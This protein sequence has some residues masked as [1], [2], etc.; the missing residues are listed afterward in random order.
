MLHEPQSGHSTTGFRCPLLGVKRTLLGHCGNCRG[1]GIGAAGQRYMP[2]RGG[3]R[4][5][6]WLC[7]CRM[8]FDEQ[9]MRV[10][11]LLPA[12][13]CSRPSAD[14]VS[15]CVGPTHARERSDKAQRLPCRLSDRPAAHSVPAADGVTERDAFAAVAGV[16]FWHKAH[17]PTRST[18]VRFRG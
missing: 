2:R 10:H 12:A 15:H 18:H 4:D 7:D 13:A 11:R 6:A 9:S 17:I 3:A 8:F 1:R 14:G 5:R 16:C